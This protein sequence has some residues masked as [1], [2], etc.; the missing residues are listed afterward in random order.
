MGPD[1]YVGH[2]IVVVRIDLIKALLESLET[3]LLRQGHRRPWLVPCQVPRA[4]GP[5]RHWHLQGNI[6]ECQETLPFSRQAR[7]FHATP[8]GSL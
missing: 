5:L 7:S 1:G 2:P 3:G 4:I 8:A 6:A